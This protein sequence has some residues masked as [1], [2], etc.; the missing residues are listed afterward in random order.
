LIDTDDLSFEANVLNAKGTV[1]A[2]FKSEWCASCKA[3]TP[4][5]EKLSDE[6]KEKVS[7]Y[8]VDIMKSMKTA[9]KHEVLAIPTLIIFKDGK[10]VDRFTG[11]T[12]EKELKTIIERQI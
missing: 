1:L 12:S 7:F 2:L 8:K 3:I 9:E 6:F 5:V 11:E 4:T 10:E